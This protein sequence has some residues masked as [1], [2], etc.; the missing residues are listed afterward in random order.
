LLRQRILRIE[1]MKF[2]EHLT[3]SFLMAQM[4]V[5][6]EYGTA[7]TILV[8]LAGNLPDLDTLTFFFNR[9][10]FRNYHRIVGHGLPV[11]LAGP[12][13]L[14]WFGSQVL[15]L[16]PFLPLWGWLQAGLLVHLFTDI[17]FYRWPVQ[18]L[19]PVSSRGWAFGWVSWNDLVPTLVLYVASALVLFWPGEAQRIALIGIGTF[20]A[21]LGWR[22]WRPRPELGWEGWLTGGWTHESARFWR[23][24]TGDI[25]T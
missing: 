13:L 18:V 20:G 7:G 5:Q 21:Y 3:L 1:P 4:Q 16:G 15:K 12:A 6:P 11:T 24:L 9:R 8:L 23:W 19:W 2:P 14:A 22:A 10:L 25:V 17:S